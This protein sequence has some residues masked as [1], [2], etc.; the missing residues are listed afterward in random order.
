MISRIATYRIPLIV[1]VVLVTPFFIYLFCLANYIPGVDETYQIEA[2]IRISKGLGNTYSWLVGND[3]GVTSFSYQKAWPLGYSYFLS[4]F[5]YIGLPLFIALKLLKSLV[6][7]FAIYFWIRFGDIFL[8]NLYSRIL[9]AC[10][11]AGHVILCSVSLT[12]TVVIMFVPLFSSLMLKWKDAI[13]II[14]S[15]GYQILINPISVG[16]AV[17]VVMVFKYSGWSL[18]ITGVTWILLMN[19]REPRR[20]F[21]ALLK[22]SLPII[23]ALIIIITTNSSD[24]S[25]I[26]SENIYGLMVKSGFFYEGWAS[27]FFNAIFSSTHLD[28]I[29][30]KVPL[31]FGI[32]GVLAV[33]II[34]ILFFILFFLSICLLLLRGEKE[35]LL[36]WWVIVNFAS[37][38][39]FLKV[40]TSFYFVDS[41]GWTPVKEERFYW[42][43]LPFLG[44]CF[45][46]A[47]D[48]LTI[49]VHYFTKMLIIISALVF[50]SF[51]ISYYSL[52]K[53]SI[54]KD[55]NTEIALLPWKID[56]L[57]EKA[58]ADNVVFFGDRI[59]WQ[60]YP[61]K[62]K[63]NFF[64][65][66]PV[67]SELTYF[68]K[69]TIVIMICSCK[70]YSKESVAGMTCFAS[71]FEKAAGKFQFN[72]TTSGAHSKIYW[73]VYPAGFKFHK[74]LFKNNI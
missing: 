72:L 19:I 49:R 62:G 5:L 40:V 73:K 30:D 12:D 22:F 51:G 16:I 35:A 18:I 24:S 68:S 38:I 10:L 20:C 4:L 70:D 74:S 3:L 46:V 21:L 41:Y 1:S 50:T 55:L 65:W 37:A 71:N 52:N 33:V 28:K 39:I 64:V 8:K 7:L 45:F 63:F 6:I 29:V 57:L 69:K 23:L 48:N 61:D 58:K 42:A 17:A 14:K 15:K 11:I 9:F 44:L 56:P 2:A 67:F 43:L 36:G 25:Q 13:F 31:Y 47:A 26:N 27:D 66:A 53:Y 59:N 32:D 54:Y 60:L 34:K